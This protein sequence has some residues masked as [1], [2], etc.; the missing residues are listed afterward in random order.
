MHAARTPNINSAYIY[1]YMSSL[2]VTVEL[3]EII[4]LEMIT[5]YSLELSE[6][7]VSINTG[8]EIFVF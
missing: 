3:A 2:E 1:F 5:H 4:I 8:D 7:L 6:K